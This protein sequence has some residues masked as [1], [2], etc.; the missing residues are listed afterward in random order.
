[1]YLSPG[2]YTIHDVDSER[3]FTYYRGSDE[4]G[5]WAPGNDSDRKWHVK[6]YPAGDSGYAIQSV[7][8]NKYIGANGTNLFHAD[9]GSATTLDLE[10]QFKDYYLIKVTGTKTYLSHPNVQ[11]DNYLVRFTNTNI[12]RGCF[13]RF[14]KLNDDAGSALSPNKP[15]IAKIDTNVIGSELLNGLSIEDALF[16]TDALFN[17]RRTSFT[18]VQRRAILNWA[19]RM[20]TTNVPTMESFDEYEKLQEDE[21]TGQ[22]ASCSD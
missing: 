3:V 19:R 6:S 14:E 7:A 12:P 9:E 8:S 18:R 22:N 20:G 4:F 2:T 17:I 16:Y 1:M 10:H 15:T 11:S 5:T 13:W 21:S